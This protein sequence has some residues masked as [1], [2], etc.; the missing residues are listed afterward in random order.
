MFNSLSNRFYAAPMKTLVLLMFV[1]LALSGCAVPKYNHSPLTADISEPPLL[2]APV[3]LEVDIVDYQ[4]EKSLDGQAI[5]G[6]MPRVVLSAV[7]VSC[8]GQD[9]TT[10]MM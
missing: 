3:Y 10:H 1:F 4:Y 9:L 6:V 7:D 5:I 8:I 2:A